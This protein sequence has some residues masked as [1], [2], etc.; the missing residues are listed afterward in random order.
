MVVINRD[1]LWAFRGHWWG[2]GDEI[3]MSTRTQIDILLLVTNCNGNVILVK[4]NLPALPNAP[5]W[6]VVTVR[7]FFAHIENNM[8]GVWLALVRAPGR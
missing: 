4:Y 5:A 1:A 6:Y 3:L 2:W 8:L 7:F